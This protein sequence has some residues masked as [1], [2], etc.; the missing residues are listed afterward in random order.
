[1]W[2]SILVAGLGIFL[3]FL[4]YHWRKISSAGVQAVLPGAH[5]VLAHK[6]Y[7]DEFNAAVPVRAQLRLAKLAGGFDKL[8][9]D[10]IVN[11]VG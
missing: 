2:L 8:I 3:S 9:V 11:G 1:M 7:C 4:T 5:R 10:G 6:Y